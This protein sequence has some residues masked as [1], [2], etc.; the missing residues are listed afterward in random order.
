MHD[1]HDNPP[2]DKKAD[3]GA[4]LHDNRNVRFHERMFDYQFVRL[5]Q[6]FAEGIWISSNHRI[7][8]SAVSNIMA[9]LFTVK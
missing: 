8:L 7:A 5:G 3:L 2:I 6:H 9:R 4:A 1:L